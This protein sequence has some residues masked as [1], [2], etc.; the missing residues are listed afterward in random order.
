VFRFLDNQSAEAAMRKNLLRALLIV[1]ITGA[2]HANQAERPSQAPAP[3]T[4]SVNGITMAYESRGPANAETVLLIGGTGMQMTEWPEALIQGLLKRGFRVVRFDNRDAGLSTH[5]ASLGPP[6]WAAITAAGQAGRAPPLPYTLEDM[7]RDTVG[8]MSALGVSKAHIAGVSQGGI[9]AQ[10]VAILFPGRVLSLVPIVCG[11]GNPVHPLVAHPERLAETS[12]P[13]KGDDFET[14]VAYR[15]KVGRAFAGRGYPR[16]EAALHAEAAALIRRNY[17]P[18]GL[19]R[20]QAAALIASFQDRRKA[21]SSVTV[22]AIVIQGDDDPLVP[23]PSAREVAQSIPGAEFR[24]IPGM[25]H[26]IPPALAPQIVDAI[27]VAAARS[28]QENAR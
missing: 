7:A 15:V 17:D 4:A 20:Q 6:D 18:V 23:I 12:A 11:S 13:P 9:V 25:G 28:R 26:D 3:T 5:L 2:A 27:A 19:Q 8:L 22:P 16:S 10:D 24:L 1:V 21:L 14:L